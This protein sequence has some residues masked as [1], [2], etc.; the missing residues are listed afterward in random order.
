[1]DENLK[2]VKHSCH[3]GIDSLFK[4]TFGDDLKFF[5]IPAIFWVPDKNPLYKLCNPKRISIS[6]DQNWLTSVIFEVKKLHDT[7]DIDL[8]IWDDY[9]NVSYKTLFNNVK[10]TLFYC[11]GHYLNDFSK[12]TIHK[13]FK[14]GWLKEHPL[15]IFPTLDKKESFA[16]WYDLDEERCLVQPMAVYKHVLAEAPSKK[17]NGKLLSMGNGIY[18]RANLYPEHRDMSIDIIENLIKNYKDNF[19]IAG[20]NEHEEWKSNCIGFV[21]DVCSLKNYSIGIYPLGHRSPSV[22]LLETMALGIPCITMPREGFG[23]EENGKSYFIA[24]NYLEFSAY[25]RKIKKDPRIAKSIGLNGRE[26]INKNFSP[27]KWKENVLK[28]VGKFYE[29]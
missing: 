5:Q 6:K 9:N 25:I 27:D 18:D 8:F 1:M 28:F 22:S 7:Y 12:N 26:F 15:M 13:V 3:L 29:K 16:T 4:Y 21:E 24:R 19:H 23:E 2:A 11:H 14:D 17:K 20:F 10:Q